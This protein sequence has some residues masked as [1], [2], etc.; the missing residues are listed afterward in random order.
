MKNS[1]GAL[2]AELFARGPRRMDTNQAAMKNSADGQIAEHF[3]CGPRRM[4]TSGATSETIDRS[5][6]QPYRLRCTTPRGTGAVSIQ[7][8]IWR[9]SAGSDR[10]AERAAVMFTLSVTAKLNDV[11]PRLAR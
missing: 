9:P 1:D 10:G 3:A 5:L 8:A 2:I 6:G 4:D 7:P 11:D